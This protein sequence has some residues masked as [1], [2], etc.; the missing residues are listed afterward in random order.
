MAPVAAPVVERWE[1]AWRA[2]LIGKA[3]VAQARSK[4]KFGERVGRGRYG[5]VYVS[6]GLGDQQPVAIKVV[7]CKSDDEINWAASELQIMMTVSGHHNIMTVFEAFFSD[8]MVI[9][10]SQAGGHTHC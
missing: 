9:D 1:A 2:D 6:S 8:G 10:K 4:Y 3:T 7:E 5:R